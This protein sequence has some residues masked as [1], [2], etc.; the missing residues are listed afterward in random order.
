MWVSCTLLVHEHYSGQWQVPAN[1]ETNIWGS[2]RGWKVLIHSNEFTLSWRDS[3]PWRQSF[4]TRNIALIIRCSDIHLPRCSLGVAGTVF[5]SWNIHYFLFPATS[6]EVSKGESLRALQCLDV[7]PIYRICPGTQNTPNA[8]GIL[9]IFPSAV[10]A[11][12]RVSRQP[13]TSG[14]DRL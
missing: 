10:T 9:T 7:S 4:N 3:A 11:G 2:I 1:K 6:E 5:H 13:A 12:C 8:S 14:E